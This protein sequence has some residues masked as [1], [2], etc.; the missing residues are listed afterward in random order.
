M[1]DEGFFLN[2]SQ[3]ECAINASYSADIFRNSFS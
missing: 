1:S 3:R 2:Y